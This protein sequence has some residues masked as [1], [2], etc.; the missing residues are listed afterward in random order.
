MGGSLEYAR[1]DGLTIFA[2]H[3]PQAPEPVG[4]EEPELEAFLI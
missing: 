1:T 3:L 4:A 2:V